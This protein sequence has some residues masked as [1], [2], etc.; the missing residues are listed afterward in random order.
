MSVF[1]SLLDNFIKIDDFVW[2]HFFGLTEKLFFDDVFSL[3]FLSNDNIVLDELNRVLEVLV[4]MTPVLLQLLIGMSSVLGRDYF[5]KSL[6]QSFMLHYLGLCL[7][8]EVNKHVLL[9][10]CYHLVAVK[11]GVI[12][13][14]E[15]SYLLS[16]ILRELSNIF[17]IHDQLDFWFLIFLLLWTPISLIVRG[18]EFGFG[19]EA[20]KEF[21][22]GDW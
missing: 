10:F 5:C 19:L 15:I 7:Y 18:K 22:L 12:G 2:K 14:F 20:T 1:F 9:G 8:F 6:P 11:D 3:F 16:D 4:F 13:C 21:H 17:C